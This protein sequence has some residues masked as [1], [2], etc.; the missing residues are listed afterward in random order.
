M[1]E[2]RTSP[3]KVFPFPRVKPGDILEFHEQNRIVRRKLVWI[4][5]RN[6]LYIFC[7][8]QAGQKSMSAGDLAEAMG[9]GRVALAQRKDTIIERAVAAVT[10]PLIAA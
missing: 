10:R 8:D 2:L 1:R 4:S 7:S 9:L 5:P 6:S 3:S